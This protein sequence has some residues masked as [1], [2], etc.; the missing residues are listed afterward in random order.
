MS[1]QVRKL[2]SQMKRCGSALVH[3]PTAML[4]LGMGVVVGASFY[5]SPLIGFSAMFV[6]GGGCMLFTHDS[7]LESFGGCTFALSAVAGILLSVSGANFERDL[8]QDLFNQAERSALQ[9][10]VTALAEQKFRLVRLDW[11]RTERHIAFESKLVCENKAETLKVIETRMIANDKTFTYG[12][13]Y[14]EPSTQV[15][16][17]VS[18]KAS[19]TKSN[20]NGALNLVCE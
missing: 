1:V 10:G 17:R 5:C 15:F 6:L 9:N 13:S 8:R 20:Y 11:G 3:S 18:K 19:W 16:S 14:A 2:C 12:S 4:S 7:P